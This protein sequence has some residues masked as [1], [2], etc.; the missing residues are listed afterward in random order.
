MACG[1]W[2]VACGRAGLLLL[3]LAAS[4]SAAEP[5][6]AVTVLD[7][8]GLPVT[9]L[10]PENFV[11]L[12][13]KSPRP[14]SRAEYQQDLVDVVLMIDTSAHT[15]PGRAEIERIAGLL[16]GQLGEKE[17]MAIVSYATSAD[18]VQDFTSSRL[19]L[20]RAV[21]NFRYGNDAAILDSVYAALDGAFQNS[22]ARPV[23]LILSSGADS[24]NRVSLKDTMELARRGNVSI[25][26]LSLSGYGKDPLE[27]LAQETA[28]GFYGGK[29]LRHMAQ[30]A[31][32]LFAAFRGHYELT[33]A[34][35]ELSPS[36]R[37]EGKLRVEVR[38]GEGGKEKL[39]VSF[40]PLG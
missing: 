13:D 24:R 21:A 35:G 11:V 32:N 7:S 33:F 28:G 29:E 10:K 18:L 25:F 6:L 15:G 38:R 27:K 8:T 12:Q 1:P 26:S 37:S 22:S 39:Q 23:L 2:L 40:R 20:A 5:R 14:V 19:L 30:L 9:D 31:R 34:G 16:I 4:V 36:A 17:Q 3:L